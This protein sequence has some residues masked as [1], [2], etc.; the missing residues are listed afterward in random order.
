MTIFDAASPGE[1]RQLFAAAIAAHRERASEFCTFE[2]DTLPSD[3]ED[4]L[5][6][7]MQVGTSTVSMDCTDAELDRLK[8]LVGDY[9]DFRIDE[10]ISPEEADGTHARISSRSDAARLA[11]FCDNVFQSVF[12]YEET[13]RGWVVSI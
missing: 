4:D 7:W 6:P 12:G 1:R 10:L 8:T 2:P 9:P 5:V 11:S 13:Y 3:S